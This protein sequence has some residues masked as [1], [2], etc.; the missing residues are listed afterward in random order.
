M[1]EEISWEV[2]NGMDY[3][4]SPPIE[5]DGGFALVIGGASWVRAPAE[6]G[7]GK[8]YIQQRGRAV[9]TCPVCK[10]SSCMDLLELAEGITVRFCSK[11]SQYLW[12]RTETLSAEEKSDV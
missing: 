9:A 6:L 8:L 2:K 12:A 4:V 10:L 1:S 7:G 3:R 11:C 5:M